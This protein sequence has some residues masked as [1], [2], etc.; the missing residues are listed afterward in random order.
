MTPFCSDP[1]R[2]LYVH[3]P[4]C[5][6]KCDYCAFYSEPSDGGTIQRFVRALTR[7]LELV[8]S[9]TRPATVFFGGGTP[10]LLTA[11]QWEDILNALERLGLSGACEWTIECNPATV[12][13]E[14]ARLWRE[15]G[16]N[17][18]SLGV[19]SLDE[20]LLDRL[21]RIHSREAVFRS[22]DLLR[23]AGF[24]NL[25]LDLMF[26]IPGQTREH[27][28]QT[29]DE[30]LAMG[31][32]H[33]SSY[34]VTYEDDTPLFHQWQAGRVRVDEDL[35][36]AMYDELVA[37]AGA[38]GFTRY[39][40]SNFARNTPADAPA[41]GQAADQFLADPGELPGYACRHNVT[42]WRGLSYHGLGPS[43]SGFVGGV[44]T[45]N[46]SNTSFY[47]EQLEKGRRAIQTR[48][49]LPPMRRAG[50]IAA[51]GLR[52]AA[53]WSLTRFRGTTGFDLVEVWGR[54]LDELVALGWGEREPDRFRL[55]ADGLRFAD[56]VAERFVD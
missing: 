56:A 2:S 1:V 31:S 47:S 41:P 42:Y 3:V 9:E 38:R 52:L 55:T 53:G 45:T 34:E 44:R 11:R 48:D 27:W 5:T 32:E 29:L 54:E 46:W 33:L 14:K 15:R 13:L 12:S 51:F 35:A 4:F 10:S 40:V 30:A 6:R 43:A 25:N 18:L 19:Q 50:E 8:A 23:R 7:E 26:A 22:F 39:E 21:G 28:R 37:R 49:S 24:D 17:R 36:C 20:D 16:V